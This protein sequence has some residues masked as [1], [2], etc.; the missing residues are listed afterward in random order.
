MS[1]SPSLQPGRSFAI[2]LLLVTAAF[3]AMLVFAPHAGA[4][5]YTV[6]G[7]LTTTQTWATG[8]TYILAGNVT[9]DGGVTL[10]VEDEGPGISAEHL[11]HVFDRFYKADTARAPSGGSGLG[12]SIV[13]AIVERHGGRISVVS[14]PGRTVFEAWLPR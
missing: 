12:L 9:V 3:A 2:V 11:P 14:R 6:S 4:A 13:K 7:H 5:T 1:T 8:D 10:T